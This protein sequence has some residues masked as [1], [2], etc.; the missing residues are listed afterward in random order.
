MDIT[1]NRVDA[2]NHYGVAREA[3]AVYDV[4]LAPLGQGT[5]TAD[6]GT[7]AFPVRIEAEEL[8][9]RFTARVVRGVTV[10]PAIGLIAEYFEAL[11][12][13]GISGPV[14]ATNFGWLAMGQ[15]THVFDLD[16]VEGGI[17]VRRAQA[18]ERLRLL[19]GTERWPAA[20]SRY[21]RTTW[22]WRTS[23]RRWGWPG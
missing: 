12:Q 4:A 11:G 5:G 6:K 10:S 9:G 8:C 23:G 14:D 13:K 15:P 17:V 7:G 2:M 21:S 22:W 1:T 19:D 16:T 3:A 18:G 20:G